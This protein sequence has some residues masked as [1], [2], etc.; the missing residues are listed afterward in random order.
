LRIK[1]CAINRNRYQ[2]IY[3]HEDGAVLVEDCDLSENLRG[4]WYI[5]DRCNV[6]R[7]GNKE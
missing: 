1:R 4:A 5:G 3:I 2:A 7:S 6:R